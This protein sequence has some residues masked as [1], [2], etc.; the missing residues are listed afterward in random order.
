MPLLIGIESPNSTVSSP[1]L[2]LLEVYL[3]SRSTAS[4]KLSKIVVSVFLSLSAI[5]KKLKAFN[6]WYLLKCAIAMAEMLKGICIVI[7][8]AISATGLGSWAEI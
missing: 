4:G 2:Y 3:E 5:K 7:T 1:Y 8:V 6:Y